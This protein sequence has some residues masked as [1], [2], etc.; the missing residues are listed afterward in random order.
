MN[1]KA[2]VIVNPKCIRKMKNFSRLG[3]PRG[4]LVHRKTGSIKEKCKIDTLLLHTT[5]KKYHMA[6]RFVP[7]P[8]TLNDLEG[9]SPVAGLIK[10]DSTNMC[11][12]FRT[13]STDRISRVARCLG[14]S[15]ASCYYMR[16]CSYSLFIHQ[17]TDRLTIVEQF[18]RNWFI[19]SDTSGRS[20]CF[21]GRKDAERRCLGA[22]V[23]GA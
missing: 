11:A 15:W 13:V 5:N 12:T 22:V 3:P 17:K 2:Y 16:P 7:L 14:D 19:Y 20:T 4:S 21:A 23:A 10:C 8:M 18:H 6:Y 1:R 9:H